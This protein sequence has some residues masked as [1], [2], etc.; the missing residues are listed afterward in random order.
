MSIEHHQVIIVGAGPGGLSVA[1]ALADQGIKD[2]VVLEKGAVGQ[3]WLDYPSDTRLLSETTE[4]TDDNMISDVSFAE[5]FPNI[6]H[7]S[8]VMYQKYLSEVAL[9]KKIEVINF[10]EIDDVHYDQDNHTFWLRTPDSREFT[11]TYL[12]W[13]AGMFY[14]PNED[15]DCEGCFVHYSKIPYFEGITDKEVTVVGSANG[16]SGVVMQLAEPGR[17][18]TLISSRPYEI[19]EPIDSLAKENM[20]FVKD[21]ENQGLVKI[22]ENFRAKKIYSQDGKYVLESETGE[23]LTVPNRPIVC[24]GFLPSVEQVKDLVEFSEDEDCFLALSEHNESLKQPNFFVAGTIGKHTNDQGFIKEFRK[25][26][27]VVAKTIRERIKKSGE[28]K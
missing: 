11:C 12:V 20:Q 25:F 4:K 13:A 1:A 5:V 10:I 16:A 28:E 14:T 15:L 8:H 21:L 27:P 19:Q 18:V 9:Q 3:A 23:T 6:P 7:P 2:L 22:I 17:V 26:G 24:I